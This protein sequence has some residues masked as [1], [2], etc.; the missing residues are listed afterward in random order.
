MKNQNEILEKVNGKEMFSTGELASICHLA[1][2]T[3]IAAIDRGELRASRTPGGHNRISRQDA[4]E[5]LRKYQ[6]IGAEEEKKKIL[7]VD[8]EPFI[9]EIVN[10]LFDGEAS[11]YHAANGYQAG[12]LAERER[13]DLILLDILLPDIDGRDVCRHIREADFGKNCRIIAVTVLQSDVDKE[14]IFKAGFDDYIA[15]PFRISELREKITNLLS[16]KVVERAASGR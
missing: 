12:K 5:F 4:L 13:P 1:K 9:F 2:H 15:K 16:M 7:V 3:I 8:D 14:T 6:F 10:H 11:V